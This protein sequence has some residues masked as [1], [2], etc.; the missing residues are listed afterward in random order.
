MPR[1]P[2]NPTWRNSRRTIPF[3]W[4]C[5]VI[6]RSSGPLKPRHTIEPS[7]R[8]YHMLGVSGFDADEEIRLGRREQSHRPSGIRTGRR[9]R[10]Q[11]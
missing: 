3:W 9:A 6:I 5:V 2:E 4:R 1:N 7:S 10:D 11:Y 8:A